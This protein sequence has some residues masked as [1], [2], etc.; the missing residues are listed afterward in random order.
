MRK[1]LFY[2]KIKKMGRKDV[3]SELYKK[4][5]IIYVHIPKCAGTSISKL[6]YGRD[7][8]HYSC[9][10]LRRLDKK[11]Y[12]SYYKFSVV[13]N[14]WERIASTYYYAVAHA[15]DNPKTTI[16]FITKYKSFEDFVIY[17]MSS[18]LVEN[19]YFFWSSD[20][21]L[22]KPIDKIIRFEDIEWEFPRFCK[23]MGISGELPRENMSKRRKSYKDEYNS[24]MKEKIGFL[25]KDDID[26][27]KYQ[28]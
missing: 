21:Y 9:S 26:R 8:W 4:N 5:N 18:D 11:K 3:Y 28:F 20:K 24:E 17:G 23:D 22:D 2:Q 1:A 10:E 12:D 7:P 14:P 6:L 16:S 13:R 25:Y 19:H 27:F 15:Q